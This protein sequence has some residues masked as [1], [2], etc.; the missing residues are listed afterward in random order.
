LVR[1]SAP[2]RL[3]RTFKKAWRR[4]ALNPV[5]GDERPTG[6]PFSSK[7][8]SVPCFA[9][10][11]HMRLRMDIRRNSLWP[12][13]PKFSLLTCRVC[14]QWAHTIPSA[15]ANSLTF[16]QKSSSR[17]LAEATHKNGEANQHA[18]SRKRFQNTRLARLL[19][20]TG[21]AIAM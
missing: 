5:K 21:V 13:F 17:A 4:V 11:L 6:T 3:I 18:L 19:D 12:R 7:I 1:L 8:R 15:N 2:A 10:L 14:K 20:V 16:Q 9:F